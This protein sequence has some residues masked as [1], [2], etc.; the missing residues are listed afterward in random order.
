MQSG[1]KSRDYSTLAKPKA[2]EDASVEDTRL[3]YGHGSIS[4]VMRMC[5]S[6]YKLFLTGETPRYYLE[7]EVIIL[8]AT[9]P[10]YNTQI[11]PER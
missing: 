10:P 11:P 8:R 9:E 1:I 7:L 3:F 5:G 2:Y 6:L 4:I